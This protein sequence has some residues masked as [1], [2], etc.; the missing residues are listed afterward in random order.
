MTEDK[1]RGTDHSNNDKPSNDPPKPTDKDNPTTPSLANRIQSSASGLARQAFSTPSSSDAALLA[2]SGKPSSSSSALAPAEQYSQIS[3]P[4]SRSQLRDT[5]H[6]AETFRSPTTTTTTQQQGGFTIPQLTEEE[7]AHG[8]SSSLGLG[9]D[10]LQPS[11]KGKGKQRDL[12]SISSTTETSTTHGYHHHQ[13]HIL[14]PTDGS[15]VLSLLSSKTFDPSFPPSAHEP[16]DII[17]TEPS[18]PQPLS[19]AEIQMLETFRRHM[20][21]SLDASAPAPASTH[22]L[23][24]ASLVPDIDTILG[25]AAVQ[26][27]VD[28]A[29]LR[30]SVLGSLPGSEDWVAVEERYHD[31]VW[32]WL[33]PTLEAA[34][35]EI[36]ERKEK[37]GNQRGED[38]PAVQRLKM[39]LRH[40]RA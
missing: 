28:A 36:E 26:T 6:N 33:R 27:D 16:L 1:K 20:T 30:D 34:A 19:P 7:F 17:E 35:K 23:T 3:G 24:S 22:R 12:A 32:G 4:S 18:P 29:A 15:A 14:N 10:F 39:I 11:D 2:N 21:P 31:E 5:T 8:D 38:G 13:Q 25:S 9:D 40:M 37:Q